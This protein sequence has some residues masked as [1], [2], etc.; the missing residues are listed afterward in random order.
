LLVTTELRADEVAWIEAGGQ[1]LLL[2]RSSAALPPEL[3]LDRPLSIHARRPPA[4]VAGQRSPWDGDWVSTFSWLL[5]DAFPG[6]PRRAPL[7]LAYAEVLPDHVLLGFDPALHRGE[8]AAGIFA[9]WVQAPAAL[10]WTFP[11]GRGRLTVTTLRLAPESGP[12]ATVMLDELV[13]AA[14]AGPSRRS[15][16]AEGLAL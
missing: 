2:A 9:G 11:Q 1:A 5:P 13:T 16:V 7:D 3:G 10:A 12:V 4:G 15:Q 14:A 6:A 8:V